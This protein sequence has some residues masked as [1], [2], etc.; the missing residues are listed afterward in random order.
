MEFV[1]SWLATLP[2]VLIYLIVAGVIGIESMGVPLPGEITLVGA[3]LLAAEGVTNPW[4][5]AVAATAGAITGDSIGYII[6]RRGGRAVLERFGRR[7]PKHFGPAHIDRAE[8]SFEKWGAWAVFFGRFVALL[9]IVA[10]PLAGALRMP[11]RRFLVANATG[12][13][14]W[15]FGTTFVLYFVGQ[16]AEHWLKQFSWMALVAAVLFGLITTAYFKRRARLAHAELET[17]SVV[18]ADSGS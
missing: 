5:V 3:S 6:G 7:F 17:A 15:G 13:L 1:Q 14:V 12:G 10:G 16:A 8:R 2:V 9:R 18:P 11:Y 4:W